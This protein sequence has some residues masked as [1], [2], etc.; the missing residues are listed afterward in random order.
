MA[1]N[2]AAGAARYEIAEAAPSDV[3]ARAGCG[4]LLA[5][6]KELTACAFKAPEDWAAAGAAVFGG[7]PNSGG[8]SLESGPRVGVSAEVASAAVDAAKVVG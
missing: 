2:A 3:G 5:A 6:A 4:V 1:C 7:V 8:A